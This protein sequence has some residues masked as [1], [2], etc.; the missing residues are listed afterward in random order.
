MASN[1]NNLE[2]DFTIRDNSSEFAKYLPEKYI[3]PLTIIARIK[4]YK[5]IDDYILEL[6][7][8]RVEMFTDTRDSIEYEDFQKYMHNTIIGEDVENP[9]TRIIYQEEEEQEG[10]ITTTK[11]IIEESKEEEENVS[12]FVN[13]VHNEHMQKLEREEI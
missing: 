5:G 12:D 10:A 4:G 13:K 3:E 6:I 7:K 11:Q 1:N 8:D 9:W 2:H